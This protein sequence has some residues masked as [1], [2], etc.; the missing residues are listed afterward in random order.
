LKK[1]KEKGLAAMLGLFLFL[2]L[3]KIAPILNTRPR[4]FSK[5]LY[6]GYKL[7]KAKVFNSLAKFRKPIC[8]SSEALYDDHS[9]PTND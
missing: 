7:K 4:R 2:E 3:I 1:C 5:R 8:F 9:S 6:S